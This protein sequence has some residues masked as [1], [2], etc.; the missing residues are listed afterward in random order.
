MMSYFD[1]SHSAF[2]LRWG[3][4][5]DKRLVESQLVVWISVFSRETKLFHWGKDKEVINLFLGL[6]HSPGLTSKISQMKNTRK[7]WLGELDTTVGLDLAKR[8]RC[9]ARSPG[10]VVSR[11]AGVI[12][13]DHAGTLREAM[14]E[15]LA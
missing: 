11:R 13:W 12:R 7:A 9:Q 4:D 1:V 5:F 10:M 14:A 8:C 3:L 6:P 2:D 15:R